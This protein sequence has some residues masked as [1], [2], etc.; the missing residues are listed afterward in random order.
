MFQSD[1]GKANAVHHGSTQALSFIVS[2]RYL[3]RSKMR[4]LRVGSR[5][6]SY[7]ERAWGW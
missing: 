2:H 7:C 1:M 4:Q 6:D 5:R 3:R